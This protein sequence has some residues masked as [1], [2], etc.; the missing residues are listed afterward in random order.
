MGPTYFLLQ[1]SPTLS[2]ISKT[3]NTKTKDQNNEEI[4]R[5]KF[6]KKLATIN[7]LINTKIL[8]LSSQGKLFIN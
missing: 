7:I 6:Q 4:A 3:I 1:V 8:Q 2:K 5:L